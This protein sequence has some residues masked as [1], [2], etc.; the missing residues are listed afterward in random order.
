MFTKY[1][2]SLI[3]LILANKPLSFQGTQVTET[4][5]KWLL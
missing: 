2:K 5:F 4:G 3:D 1:N